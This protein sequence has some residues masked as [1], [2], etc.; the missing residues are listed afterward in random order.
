MHVISRRLLQARLAGAPLPI[1]DYATDTKSVLDQSLR[2]LNAMVDISADEGMARA[3]LSVMRL[4]QCVVQVFL[5]SVFR[6]SCVIS[7]FS[8]VVLHVRLCRHN[9]HRATH[10]SNFLELRKPCRLLWP[11]GWASFQATPLCMTLSHCLPHV[12][13]QS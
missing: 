1:A 13:E 6:S 10:F 9:C 12:S 8:L 4:V 3:C 7:R 5:V 2:I 11:A